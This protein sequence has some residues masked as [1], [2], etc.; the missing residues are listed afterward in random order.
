MFKC[1]VHNGSTIEPVYLAVAAA[2]LQIFD[3]YSSTQVV[4]RVRKKRN[5]IDN[6]LNLN[7]DDVACCTTGTIIPSSFQA[8]YVSNHTL[9]NR[10]A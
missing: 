4:L 5:N 9:E 3:P 7:I 8:R 6:Y 1:T 10:H 2:T